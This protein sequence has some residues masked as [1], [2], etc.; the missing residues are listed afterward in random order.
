M[1]A[2]GDGSRQ[3]PF[4][5]PWL[6]FRRAEPGDTIHIA[7]GTY[8]GRFDRSSWIVDC[9]N[10]TVRGGYNRDFT[11]RNP[12]KMPTILGFYSGYEAAHENNLITGR[13]NHSGLTLNRR[14]FF[15]AAGRNTYG[16]K[17]ADGITWYPSMDGPIAAFSAEHVTI[18]NCVFA[19][20]ANGGVEL[21][22]A[23]SRFENNLL[24]NLIGLAMLDLRSSSQPIDPPITAAGNAFCF[25]HDTGDPA[26]GGG[27]RSLGI[28]INCP[29]AIENNVF[30]SCGNS[31]VTTLLDPSRVSIERNLFFAAPHNL[32][33]SHACRHPVRSPAKNLDEAEDL[34]SN[35]SRAIR[36]KTP[37]SPASA[38][39]ADVYSRHLVSHY[40]TPP[41][42][43]ANA[44]RVTAGLP[45]L[46]P[47]D[48]EKQEQKGAL[49]PRFAVADALALAFG[50][51]P[52]AH[53]IALA[54]AIAPPTAVPVAQYHPIEWTSILAPDPSLTNQR[55][56]LRAGLGF[57]QNAFLLADAAPDTH[58]G[59]RIF[60]PGSDDNSI[61]VLIR[62]NT[63]PTRQ[64]REAA[65]YN[66]GMEVERTYQLRGIY[67]ADVSGS[68]QKSTV[69]VESIAP[70]ALWAPLPPARPSGRD[71][72]VRAG[73]TGGD[74]TREKPFRDPF[75]A[76]EKAQAGDNI[77][78]AAG[79]TSASCVP[80]AGPSPP[81]N[82][83]CSAGTTTRSPHAIRGSIP[84]ASCSMKSSGQRAMP[85]EMC[86]LPRKIATASWWTALFSMA[87]PA[88]RTRMAR[89]MRAIRRPMRWSASA[90]QI[91]P[92]PSAIVC[93]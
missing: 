72:F 80:A 92:S 41:R 52:G 53:P 11:A 83:R 19:N 55:V 46:T 85:A 64:Y 88:I 8:Y 21:S 73:A 84:R 14:Y 78:V 48:L 42:E 26:G 36:W 38:G 45:A 20:S 71:W 27:D 34:V 91:V 47:A 49:A 57:E 61:F 66:R 75:Q 87:R 58:M 35:P 22:G 24:L 77:H 50:A 70:G 59:V 3:S 56:E 37:R 44:M 86:C 10:L 76:L 51:K 79:S 39:M 65:L 17:P 93:S 9:P 4:H 1:A 31:A 89:W 74:G 23:G 40:A 82:W 60:Q 5:D 33:E 25:M 63:L 29:A 6:A 43:A 18:R 12:W 69:I 90:A 30:V 16:D 2:R 7:A 54:V 15:D 28:R 32:V 67:R 68:L 13:E 81:R 62:R